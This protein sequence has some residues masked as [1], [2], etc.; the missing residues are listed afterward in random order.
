MKKMI[1]TIQAKGIALYYK[2]NT[3]LKDKHGT[4][5]IDTAVFS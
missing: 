5:Y 2:T 3:V 1:N 4:G